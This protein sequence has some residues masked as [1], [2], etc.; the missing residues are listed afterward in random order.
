MARHCY[1]SERV[2]MAQR[3]TSTGRPRVD[4]SMRLM[5]FLSNLVAWTGVVWRR[6]RSHAT[7][8][9]AVWAGCTLAVALVVSIPV[10][11][12]AAGYRILLAELAKSSAD[13]L[14]PPFSMIST[15]GSSGAKP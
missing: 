8:L 5:I 11:A 1:D 4:W 14:L 9:L 12:E 15:Y 7:L 3:A 2:F 13:D 10:Y 6:V